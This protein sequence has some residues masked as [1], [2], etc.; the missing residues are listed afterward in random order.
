VR[1][2]GGVVFVEGRA[3]GTDDLGFAAH[4]EKHMGMVERRFG[5]DAHEFACAD[6]DLHETGIIV[7]VRN[8]VIRHDRPICQT[9]LSFRTI[10][11]VSANW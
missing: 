2:K 6:L 11:G 7:K 4:V 9:H 10:A 5:T 1:V 8:H 3:I